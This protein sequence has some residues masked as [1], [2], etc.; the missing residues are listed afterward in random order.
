MRIGTDI[1]ED[2]GIIVAVTPCCGERSHFNAMLFTTTR[3]CPSCLQ[4]YAVEL[5]QVNRVAFWD[6]RKRP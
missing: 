6:R 4:P 2:G 1:T 3:R 5:D